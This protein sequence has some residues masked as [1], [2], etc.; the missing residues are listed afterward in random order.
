[1]P[2]NLA[3]CSVCGRHVY[4][5]AGQCPF[6][7][8]E[9]ADGGFPRRALPDAPAGLPRKALM[10]FAATLGLA[11]GCSSA[12]MPADGG[13]AAANDGSTAPDAQP[14]ADASV[15]HDNGGIAPPYG[16]PP[17]DF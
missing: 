4:L 15:P 11:A 12:T 10:V 13:D 8:R 2:S 1:M 6:C 16:V 7:A 3:P 5:A 17:G 14:A 9:L